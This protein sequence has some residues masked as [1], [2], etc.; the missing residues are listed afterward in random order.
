MGRIQLEMHAQPLLTTRQAASFLNLSHR[1]LEKWR[2]TGSGP[3]YF[4]VGAQVRYERA[5]L[6]RWLA[7]RLLSHTTEE[8]AK[9]A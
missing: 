8:S 7:E 3:R 4:K 5:E 6:D 2:V 1:T 9:V